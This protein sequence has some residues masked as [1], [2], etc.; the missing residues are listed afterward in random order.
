MLDYLQKFELLPAE[1][2]QKVSNQAVILTIDQLEKKYGLPLASLVMKVMIK[3]ISPNDLAAYFIS[4]GLADNQAGELTEE[5]KN[6][7]FKQVENYL[8]VPLEK[9]EAKTGVLPE[10]SSGQVIHGANF[11]FSPEDEQEIRELT[12]TYDGFS[13]SQA[14]ASQ[15]DERIEQIIGQT[16]VNFGSEELAGRFRQ[17]L[18]TYLKGI[19]DR[20]EV[21]Q[22]LIK[23]FAS[24][25]LSFDSESAEKILQI[26]DSNLK[27]QIKPD[28]IKPLAKINLP[29]IDQKTKIDLK[30]V[31]VRDIEYNLASSLAKAKPVAKEAKS[32]KFKPLDT[33]HELAPPPLTKKVATPV[34]PA[35]S[36]N[37]ENLTA[38]K[39][40]AR[41]QPDTLNKV[42]VEDV[43]YVPRIMGP[44]D[45]LKYMDLTSFR[46]L[47]QE[48]RQSVNKIKEVVD[49]LE[50][51]SYGKRLE[52]IKAW[53]NSP[54][55]KLY[56]LS[57]QQSIKE[58]KSIEEI[59]TERKA[60]GEEYLT[61]EEFTAIMD[62]NKSLRF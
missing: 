54:T 43:K 8:A 20:I 59:I 40:S 17:I 44:I 29:G 45:E 4:Q 34:K 22:T 6:K 50:E 31:G 21:K 51:E 26:T 15:I 58:N 32:D 12:K 49:L 10:A 1:L 56:I 39:P 27:R 60:G 52:A 11:F 41:R 13:E 46:R 18:R 23:P 57:G 35:P 9:A 36:I 55:Y 30:N 25:G 48:P 47:S 24:G 33:S 19:R 14:A 16:Q 61:N 5:L 7:A 3:E 2:R 38:I 28:K 53:R 62:L 42:R 37:K